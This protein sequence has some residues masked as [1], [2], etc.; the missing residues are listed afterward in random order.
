MGMKGRKTMTTA[1]PIVARHLYDRLTETATKLRIDQVLT[2]HEIAVAFMGIGVSLAKAEH[3]PAMAA[4]W[5]RDI[6]DHVE[7][8]EPALHGKLQ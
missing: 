6:A 5:L 2:D 8:D 4:E 7:R 1:N 3:G